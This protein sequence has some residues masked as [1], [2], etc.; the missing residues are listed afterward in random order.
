ERQEPTVKLF[1]TAGG[2]PA[3]N[4]LYT[5]IAFF[6]NPGSGWRVFRLGDFL[7]YRILGERENRVDLEMDYSIMD[8][9]S[10]EIRSDTR[11]VI[12][13]WTPGA[14]GEGPAAIT[15]TGAE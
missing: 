1:G 14:D 8:P 15:V 2:D 10:G 4:G 3:M 11:R 9:H 13:T 7:E 5:Y 6:E 12:V